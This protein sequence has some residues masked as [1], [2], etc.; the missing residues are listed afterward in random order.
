MNFIIV[1]SQSVSFGQQVVAFL[2]GT[3]LLMLVLVFFTIFS[4]YVPK[5]KRAMSGLSGAVCATFLIEV[6]NFWVLGRIPVIGDFTRVIG[7]VAG[8]LAAPACTILVII[9]MGGNPLFA[10]L[11]GTAVFGVGLSVDVD[12]IS[13][14][15]AKTLINTNT[16]DGQKLLAEDNAIRVIAEWV[17]GN[18]LQNE[19]QKTFETIKSNLVINEQKDILKTIF[20]TQYMP[21]F[22]MH[23]RTTVGAFNI[24]AGLVAGYTMYW[25]LLLLQKYAPDGLDLIIALLII[26]PLTALTAKFG[27]NVVAPLLKGIGSSIEVAINLSP[28]PMAI[29]VGGFLTVVGTSPLS[30]MALAVGLGLQGSAMAVGSVSAMGSSFMNGVLFARM[31]YGEKKQTIACSIEPLSQA[32]II[33]MNPV[34]VYITNFIGAAATG[35]LVIVY[36]QN[37]LNIEQTVFMINSNSYEVVRGFTQQGVG[38]ATPFGPVA[39][40]GQG[41]GQT[42]EVLTKTSTQYATWQLNMHLAILLVL[43]AILNVGAGLLGG[44]MFRNSRRTTYFEIYNLPLPLKHQYLLEEIELFQTNKRR[45]AWQW[46]TIIFFSKIKQTIRV[47]TI[48]YIKT[49]IDCFNQFLTEKEKTIKT[50]KEELLHISTSKQEFKINFKK[51]KQQIITDL[52]NKWINNYK[53]EIQK[54]KQQYKDLLLHF[55]NELEVLN[56]LVVKNKKMS[57]SLTNDDKLRYQKL[58]SDFKKTQKQNHDLAKAALKGSVGKDR[59]TKLHNKKMQALQDKI[60]FYKEVSK[61]YPQK[62]FIIKTSLES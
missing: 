48:I 62:R 53:L 27:A 51:E 16:P 25:A 32:D 26:A 46:K 44:Y 10:I 31:K 49:F 47:K 11:C 39:M 61:F 38:L 28:I 55:K 34:S 20:S 1:F 37:I 59:L 15:I 54:E 17:K 58:K 60:N 13:K 21:N 50:K 12:G 35:I 56:Q 33:S 30:S 40:F 2:K 4:Y 19:M 14:S 36:G 57:Q 3:S 22:A 9:L 45:F 42:A 8:T 7:S 23:L 41:G 18:T 6:F 29:V 5:G 52:K 43:T 24:L